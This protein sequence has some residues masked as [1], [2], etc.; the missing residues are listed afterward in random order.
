MVL[1]QLF[2]RLFVEFPAAFT[3]QVFYENACQSLFQSF[4][5]FGWWFSAG[6]DGFYVRVLLVE[7]SGCQSVYR[8]ILLHLHLASTGSPSNLISSNSTVEIH[9]RIASS[10]A[11]LSA[12]LPYP[13]LFIA[14][15]LN[16]RSSFSLISLG[17]RSCLCV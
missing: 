16:L 14:S 15:S 3:L 13:N 1:K 11:F 9:I 8:R 10:A 4:S 12:P 17:T 6:C 5:R 7:L 2:C